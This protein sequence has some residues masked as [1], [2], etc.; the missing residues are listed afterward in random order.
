M[1]KR[2]VIRVALSVVG[3]KIGILKQKYLDKIGTIFRTVMLQ[4]SKK[5]FVNVEG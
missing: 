2:D 5:Y 1:K 3:N 4:N